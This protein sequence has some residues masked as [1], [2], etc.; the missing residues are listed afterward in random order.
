MESA[1][2]FTV[3]GSPARDEN[4]RWVKGRVLQPCQ[5]SSP[6]LLGQ[7]GLTRSPS[8]RVFLTRSPR[9]HQDA[10]FTQSSHVKHNLFDPGFFVGF[11]ATE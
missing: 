7:G 3:P 5:A 2:Y 9:V 6:C 1:G 8:A 4:L 11:L 10:P